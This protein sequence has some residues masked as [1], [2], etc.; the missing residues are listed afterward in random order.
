M[1][2]V[3]HVNMLRHQGSD[4][5]NAWREENPAVRPDLSGVDLMEADLN[6]ANLQGADLSMANLI[7]ARLSRANLIQHGEPD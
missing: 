1:V 6:G 2:N 5:W 4:A 3:D 7:R